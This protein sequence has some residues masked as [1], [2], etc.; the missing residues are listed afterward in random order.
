[1]RLIRSWASISAYPKQAQNK[2][3]QNGASFHYCSMGYVIC[4]LHMERNRVGEL[5]SGPLCC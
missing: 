1:M 3:T 5:L 4:D 2:T